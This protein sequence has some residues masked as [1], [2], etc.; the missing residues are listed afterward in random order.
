[1]DRL[2]DRGLDQALGVEAGLEVV[3]RVG[4]PAQAAA[5]VEALVA[6]RLGPRRGLEQDEG[7]GAGLAPLVG[8]A[9][10]VVVQ[11]GRARQAE[12]RGDDLA[13]DRGVEAGERQLAE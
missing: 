1:V 2:A 12:R 6:V 7:R 13:V 11:P 4:L 3:Q 8:R 10:Q 9:A 5:E